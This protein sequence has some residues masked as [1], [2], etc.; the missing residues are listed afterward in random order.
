M[1]KRISDSEDY[2]QYQTIYARETG[3]ISAPTA[4]LHFNRAML[5]HF[6]TIGIKIGFFTLYIDSATFL[7]I[8][9]Q[10]LTT[11]VMHE[12]SYSL[13][14]A[15]VNAIHEKKSLGKRVIAVETT[16]ANTRTIASCAEVIRRIYNHLSDKAINGNT[17]M[18]IKPGDRDQIVDALIKN[19]H[20]PKSILLILVSAFAGTK[21]IQKAYAYTVEK[22]GFSV[23]EMLHLLRLQSNE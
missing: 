15:T 12:E 4:G 5:E 3:S 19:F 13:P 10:D 6:E 17:K 20:L 2:Q 23:M 21:V 16:S 7:L 8:K 9:T 22:F 11:H 1:I 14:T 18:F